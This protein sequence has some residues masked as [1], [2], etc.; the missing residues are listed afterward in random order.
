MIQQPHPHPVTMEEVTDPV[1]VAQA[2]ARRR[3]FDR[4]WAWFQ[5]Q[6]PQVLA[7]NRGRFLAIAG[8]ELFAGETPE[9]AIALARAAHP[10]DEGMFTW[11]VPRERMRRIYAHQRRVV[12]V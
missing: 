4:N 3:A 6:A 11:Y 8:E 2:R 10:G 12:S 5:R 1:L 9:E 7:A